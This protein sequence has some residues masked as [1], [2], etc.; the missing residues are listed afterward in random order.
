MH[1][2]AHYLQDKFLSQGVDLRTIAFYL[3]LDN[4]IFCKK[5]KV[6]LTAGNSIHAYI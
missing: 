1:Q 6:W 5:R 3:A 2:P 4:Q